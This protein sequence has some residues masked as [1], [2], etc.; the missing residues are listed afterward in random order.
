MSD[1]KVR[2]GLLGAGRI[3]QIHGRSVAAHKAASLAAITD[4]DAKAVAALNGLPV[5]AAA[6]WWV[7][8]GSTGRDADGPSGAGGR[9]SSGMG[10][11][12]SRVTRS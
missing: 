1:K 11:S 4:V 3:G 2:I 9:P 7:R 10:A 5:E 8:S 6:E 12:T